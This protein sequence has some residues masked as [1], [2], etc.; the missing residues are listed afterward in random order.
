MAGRT[1]L[2]CADSN[3]L[4][5]DRD[6][7]EGSSSLSDLSRKYGISRDSL[8]RHSQSHLVEITRSVMRDR[9][10]SIVADFTERLLES[11]DDLR[12]ARMRAADSGNT[13]A[14]AR[15]ADA[16]AKV[17]NQLTAKFGITN[18]TAASEVRAAVNV[19]E[20]VWDIAIKRPEIAELL[21]VTMG[22]RKH[23]D[24]AEQVRDMAKR[25][26]RENPDKKAIE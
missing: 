22:E 1:C 15:A 21:A 6:L 14:L 16:E 4:D 18:A 9:E 12:A 8:W 7:L 20:A 19:L 5:I 25:A 24:S 17:I 11:A 3:V 13:L 2:V 26:R 23:Y 10:I